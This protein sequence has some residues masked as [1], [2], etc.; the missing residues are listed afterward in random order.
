MFAAK[1]N[2]ILVTGGGTFLGDHIAA[3]LIAEGADVTTMV[4]PGNEQRSDLL[5]Q[6]VEWRTGDVWNPAS[7]RGRGRGHS[8]VIHTVGSMQ[9]DPVTGLS[10]N[11]LNFVSARNVAAMC[12]SDGI[13]NMILVSS[14]GAPWLTR[15]YIQSKREAE[16]YLGRV[17]V[18]GTII[19][20]PIVFART[21]TEPRP[22]FFELVTLARRIPPFSFFLG[23]IAPIPVDVLARGIARIAINPQ[24]TKTIYYASDLRRLNSSQER[25]GQVPLGL[26]QQQP[27][28][29]D[30]PPHP[31]ELL[32]EDTPFAWTPPDDRQ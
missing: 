25:K 7:L 17:G 22:L 6:G 3:A 20:A 15:G 2:R 5:T 12:V 4:R 9:A 32:D 16:Q 27:E 30:V 18:K 24:R 26:V 11:R 14:A 13:P 19:R 31:F 8:L 21:H 28:A 29:A 1:S 23:K 10:Y